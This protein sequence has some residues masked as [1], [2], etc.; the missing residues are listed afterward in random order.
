[1][2]VC[3]GGDHHS[4]RFDMRQNKNNQGGKIYFER[5]MQSLSNSVIRLLTPLSDHL[6]LDLSGLVEARGAAGVR[7]HEIQVVGA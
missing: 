5:T 7:E 4:F 6:S 2:C 3:G 1:M